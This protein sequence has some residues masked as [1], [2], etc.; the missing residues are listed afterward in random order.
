MEEEEKEIGGEDVREDGIIY[1][2]INQILSF[3]FILP[4]LILYDKLYDQ[5]LTE[6]FLQVILSFYY[7]QFKSS[8]ILDFAPFRWES[9]RTYCSGKRIY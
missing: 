2:F 1:V 8:Q 6:A 5:C 4:W 3:F 7:S 9:C